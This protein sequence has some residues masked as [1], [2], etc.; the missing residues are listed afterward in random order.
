MRC[1]ICTHFENRVL[2]S[3]SADSGE[4]VRRRRECLKC[5]HRF[6]TYERV[7]L[8]P[9]TVIKRNGQRELFDRAKLFSGVMRACEKTGLGPNDVNQ[10][11]DAIESELQSQP[12]REI[13]SLEIGK[14]ALEYLQDLNQVAY[15]RFA[16]VY[17]QFQTIQD[18][19]AALQDMEP[20]MLPP[21]G[22]DLRQRSSQTTSQ[23]LSQNWEQGVSNQTPLI[24]Q[25]ELSGSSESLM[26]FSIS[27]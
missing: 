20:S 4:S 12:L 23:N 16:S 15:I 24:V 13:L 14:L 2:E 19:I 25:A 17:S 7:E 1:P 3:R 21:E 8:V 10:L 6:T 27:S 5:N 9:M 22:P 18:F 26:G 11:V